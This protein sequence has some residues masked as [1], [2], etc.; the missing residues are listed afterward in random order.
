[1]KCAFCG[2]QILYNNSTF[3]NG[4]DYHH[5]CFMWIWYEKYERVKI[6]KLFKGQDDAM[7]LAHNLFNY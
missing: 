2:N 4:K 3:F 5:E 7:M 6:Y 1:M